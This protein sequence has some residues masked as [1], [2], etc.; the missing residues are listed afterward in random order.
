MTKIE[1]RRAI[2][3]MMS[4]EAMAAKVMEGL[5]NARQAE[6]LRKNANSVA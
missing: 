4:M 6:D 5:E 3:R 1:G 2:T